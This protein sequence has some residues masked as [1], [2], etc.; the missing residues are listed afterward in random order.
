M[1]KNTSHA[2]KRQQRGRQH[3]RPF[4]PLHKCMGQRE[5]SRSYAYAFAAS[6]PQL[7]RVATKVAYHLQLSQPLIR[8]IWRDLAEMRRGRRKAVA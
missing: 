4:F 1:S 5:R 7:K 6:P 2:R 3:P 8:A